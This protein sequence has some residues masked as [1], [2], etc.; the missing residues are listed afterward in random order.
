MYFFISEAD[1]TGNNRKYSRFDTELP[2]MLLA[3]CLHS[4]Q[5]SGTMPF[6]QLTYRA[7]F[8]AWKMKIYALY[9][10]QAM[11]PG[12]QRLCTG[13]PSIPSAVLSVPQRS[14]I[15]LH[16][17]APPNGDW[18]KRLTRQGKG[19]CTVLFRISAVSIHPHFPNR[20]DGSGT[21]ESKPGPHGE[22]DDHFN[23]EKFIRNEVCGK[24]FLQKK[25]L[26]HDSF[27]NIPEPECCWSRS[28]IFPCAMEMCRRKYRLFRRNWSATS[29][30][31]RN[32]NQ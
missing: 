8:S 31:I 10:I 25:N 15:W 19:Q 13:S 3:H 12:R 11:R 17:S 28:V 14:R 1:K 24:Y 30:T 26:Q 2:G 16:F 18:Q 7:F 9:S 22:S 6:A 4:P 23:N 21:A 5:E 29:S 20:W 32:D 27:F